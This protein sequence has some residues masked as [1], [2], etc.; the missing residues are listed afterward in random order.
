MEKGYGKD[1]QA[2][3]WAIGQAASAV[4]ALELLIHRAECV[5]SG[6]CDGAVG[7]DHHP[8]PELAEYDCYSCHRTIET[9]TWRQAEGPRPG[10]KIGTSAWGV[11]YYPSVRLLA[12]TPGLFASP[13]AGIRERLDE[14]AVL[15]QQ[16]YPPPGRVIAA[17][18]PLRDQLDL[19]AKQMQAD[20]ERAGA[21]CTTA[22]PTDLNRLMDAYLAHGTASKDQGD[23]RIQDWD[24]ATQTYMALTT[25]YQTVVDMDAARQNPHADAALKDARSVI[26]FP[27]PIAG[28]FLDFPREFT[29]AKFRAKLGIAGALL[30]RPA[31][32]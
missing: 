31:G 9:N 25:L 17:A 20:A 14:L 23:R 8:W 6:K 11:W 26:A 5:Q 12:E 3:N 30:P 22:P 4:Q 10:A 7:A 1:F 24:D 21:A 27:K 29:P 15:L 18:R 13:F 28:Q 2:R 19:W 32:Q 16:P